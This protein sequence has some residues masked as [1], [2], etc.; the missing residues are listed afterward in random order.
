MINGEKTR[1]RAI[2]REDVPRFVEWLN[3]PEVAYYLG[4]LPLLS[5]ADEE[6][7]FEETVRDERHRILAIDTQEGAH[8]GSI[9]LHNLDWKNSSAELGIMI[10][11]KNYWGQGYGRDAI[12]S[13]LGFGFGEL[14][15][16]RIFLR[17]Y[18]FNPRAIR[19]Y[20]NVGFQHEGVFREAV[21]LNSGYH[22]ELVMGILRGEFLALGDGKK[23]SK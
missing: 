13:L 9:G 22:N 19:C 18:D 23:P 21:Y 7:W 5:R 11:D 12:R 4:R 15:L 14:N 2:E 8:I 10:G 16:H 17:V 3:D 6:R 1:L 20:E